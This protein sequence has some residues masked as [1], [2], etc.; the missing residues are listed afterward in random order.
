V[1]HSHDIDS[2]SFCVDD[3]SNK[4]MASERLESLLQKDGTMTKEIREI[5]S[6]MKMLVHENY[7]KFIKATDAIRKMSTSIASMEEKIEQLQSNMGSISTTA[8]EVQSAMAPRR[9]KI[10]KLVAVGRLMSKLERIFELPHKLNR[11]IELRAYSIA[12]R[13]YTA[14]S[15]VLERYSHVTSF[16]KILHEAN[17]IMARLT[18][19]LRSQVRLFC[20]VTFRANPSHNLTRSP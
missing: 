11:C 13:E 2:S 17:E 3:W 5:D 15:A 14:T 10:E 12:V 1:N 7:K 20:T 18:A 16:K 4:V 19:D 9:Q 8:G 6:S